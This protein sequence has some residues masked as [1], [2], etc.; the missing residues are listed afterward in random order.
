[1]VDGDMYGE[2]VMTVTAA[3]FA[4]RP[5]RLGAGRWAWLQRVRR[6]RTKAL[7]RDCRTIYQPIE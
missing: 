6:I 2:G 7:W 1:M 3:W 4:W 5:V